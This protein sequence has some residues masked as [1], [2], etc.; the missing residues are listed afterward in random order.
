MAYVFNKHLVS[1]DG[2]KLLADFFGLDGTLGFYKC[3]SPPVANTDQCSV[4]EP[5]S[6]SPNMCKTTGIND[7]DFIHK[8]YKNILGRNVD[9]SGEQYYLSRLGDGSLSKDEILFRIAISPESRAVNTWRR[10]P[11]SL[12]FNG[13]FAFLKRKL[14]YLKMKFFSLCKNA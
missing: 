9:L 6:N 14:T 4:A 5:Q 12:Y 11:I 2:G 8:V 3:T 7:T 10:F 1:K 13:G